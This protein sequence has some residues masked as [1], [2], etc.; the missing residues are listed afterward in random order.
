MGNKCLEHGRML[1]VGNIVI[2]TCL[3]HKTAYGRIVDV[4]YPGKQMMLNLEIQPSQQPKQELVF[5][6]KVGR[7]A[8]LVDGPLLRDLIGLFIGRWEIRFLHNM[9][10]LKNDADRQAANKRDDEKPHQCFEPA[11]NQDG[12][13]EIKESVTDFCR[14]ENEMFFGVPFL[15]RHVVADLSRKIFL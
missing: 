2:G 8:H 3:F 10:Q 7:R 1:M 11:Y 5:G 9:R 15:G 13:N 4:T 6:G 12:Q 14:P